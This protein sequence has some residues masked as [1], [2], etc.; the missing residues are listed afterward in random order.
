MKKTGAPSQRVF[1]SATVFAAV[2]LT[3]SIA[4][5]AGSITYAKKEMKESGGGWNLMMTILYGSKP[6]TPHVPLR[7][8]FTPTMHYER[9]LDDAHKDQPQMRKI[10]LWGRC[11]SRKAWTWISRIRAANSMIAPSSISP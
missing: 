11:R 6:S 7:F 1:L 5:A 9:Y 8:I 4:L 3:T 10:A 2:V